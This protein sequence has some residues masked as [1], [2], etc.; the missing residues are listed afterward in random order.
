MSKIQRLVSIPFPFSPT[1]GCGIPESAFE[2]EIDRPHDSGVEIGGDALILKYS[3]IK[4][5]ADM[6]IHDGDEGAASGLAAD[7]C[8]VGK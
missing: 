6:A 2:L 5:V 3:E 1:I 4:S 7:F 8:V